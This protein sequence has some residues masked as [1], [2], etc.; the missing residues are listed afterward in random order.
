MN[1]S[2]K[3]PVADLATNLEE[4]RA[5]LI[6]MADHPMA[7]WFNEFIKSVVT[8]EVFT[9][10]DRVKLVGQKVN[11][12]GTDDHIINEVC[13]DGPDAAPSYS[14]DRGAWFEHSDFVLIERSSA[15]SRAAV[16]EAQEAERRGDNDDENDDDHDEA[17]DGPFNARAAAMVFNTVEEIEAHVFVGNHASDMAAF[18]AIHVFVEDESN[19]YAKRAEALRI[20]GE[21]GMG[22]GREEEV[23]DEELVDN[24]LA[25][26]HAPSHE[27]KKDL[28]CQFEQLARVCIKNH[29]DLGSLGDAMDFFENNP[30]L[31]RKLPAE[32]AE[33]LNTSIGNKRELQL[34]LD[35]MASVF[36]HFKLV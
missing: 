25:E 14:T 33:K 12:W 7:V 11:H 9:S 27:N 18:D 2:I 30:G 29:K 23:D 31:A 3:H 36:N 24:Y 1:T 35:A 5:S 15:A 16:I 21:K 28:L 13:I 6:L 20:M 22:F 17:V 8:P 32:V 19:T 34:M 10:G 26:H 4:V